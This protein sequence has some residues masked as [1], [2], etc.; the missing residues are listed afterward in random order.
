MI[1]PDHDAIAEFW[2]DFRAAVAIGDIDV[3][4]PL[5]ETYQVWWF[6]DSPEMASRLV[7][8]VLHGPKR[9]TAGLARDAATGWPMP[10]LHGLSIVL[11]GDGR[12]VVLLRTTEVRT[13]AF[14]SVD[15]AFAWDEGEGDRTLA[16]WIDAHRRFFER[17]AAYEGFT[18]TDDEPVVFERFEVLWPTVPDPG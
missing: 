17:Q 7:A 12:P 13:G 16:D 11:G 8:L 15:A 1:E 9:A 6:G 14:S 18:F 2:R 4:G 10:E 5:A 3:I